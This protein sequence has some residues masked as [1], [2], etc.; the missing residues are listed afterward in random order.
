MAENKYGTLEEVVEEVS[1]I[2]REGQNREDLKAV[3]YLQILLNGLKVKR[4]ELGT[5]DL[6][7]I[8]RALSEVRYAA[9]VFKPYRR[10][11]KVSIF[12]SARTP[13]HDTRYQMAVAFARQL[14]ANDYMVTKNPILS[15]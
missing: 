13:E 8:N 9:R 14:A 1:R 6:K 10:K 5:L 15:G 7:V 12:G 11:R 4:D 3:L 2:Y